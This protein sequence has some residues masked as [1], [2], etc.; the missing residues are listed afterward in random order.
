MSTRTAGGMAM[1]AALAVVAAACVTVEG[2][3][4]FPCADG[5]CPAGLACVSGQ[6]VAG[7][8]S[9]G[10]GGA[11]LPGCGNDVLEGAETCDD[12]NATDGDGCD[13]NCKPTGCG[14]GLVTQGE[15][16][17]DG[18]ATTGDGCEANCLPSPC[19]AP[20]ACWPMPNE[21]GV[22]LPNEASYAIDAMNG[23]VVDTVTG[24]MWEREAAAEASSFEEAKARCDTLSWGGFSDWRLPTRVELVSLTSD[25]RR[26]PA[27]DVDAFPDTPPSAAWT[28][29][30]VAGLA[31]YSWAV[32]F[33]DGYVLNQSNSTLSRSRCV[34]PGTEFSAPAPAPS[35]RYE[36]TA[37]TVLDT[38]TSL[39]WERA[40]ASDPLSWPEAVGRCFSLDLDGGGWRLPR[41]NELQT[42]VDESRANPAIDPTAFP[43]TSSDGFWSASS[44]VLSDASAWL[45][46][47]ASGVTLVAEKA[48]LHRVRC[49][50]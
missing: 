26:N 15:E 50:R 45:T 1:G 29:S 27:I 16:C 11:P 14:N 7:S 17:D 22:G 31:Q 44:A 47:F 40:G 39:T 33:N 41:K 18:N 28:V 9:G 24:L 20:W 4:P 10:A 36:A 3:S 35:N 5:A 34:R 2:L 48:E 21:P 13:S 12:G 6:C 46:D 25:A 38:E 43:A 23:V 37:G 19:T 32:L 42:L 8:G 30:P 49:V